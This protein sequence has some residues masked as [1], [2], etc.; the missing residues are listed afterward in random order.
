MA[1]NFLKDDKGNVVAVMC[2]KM[3]DS[4][5]NKVI[6]TPDTINFYEYDYFVIKVDKEV[7]NTDRQFKWDSY[8]DDGNKVDYTTLYKIQQQFKNA[9]E[10]YVKIDN[11]YESIEY[12]WD[13]WSWKINS[14]KDGYA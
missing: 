4:E 10:I 12:K 2:G 11:P 5:I 14:I 9:K 3:A 7:I 6:E 8:D 13:C 1:C